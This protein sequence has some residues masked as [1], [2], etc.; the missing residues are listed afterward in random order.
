M[1]K[2]LIE[3]NL[4][5]A[6]ISEQ[7]ANE[8]SIRHGVPSSI[9]RWWARRPLT[10]SRA[11]AFSA[12][13]YDPG[14][15]NPSQ[16]A[17]LIDLIRHISTWDAIKEE[18]FKYLEKARTLIRNQYSKTP[19]IIDPFAGG[20]SI[21]LETLRLGCITYAYDYNPIAVLINKCTLEWPQKFNVNLNTPIKPH[22]IDTRDKQIKLGIEYLFVTNNVLVY[23]IQKWS[24]NIY[25]EI[26]NEIGHY[27]PIEQD[28]GL[29][30][31]F[32]WARTIKCQNPECGAEIPLIRQYWL[33]KKT[34]KKTAYYPIIDKKNK[35]V[36]F[37]ILE[38]QKSISMKDFNPDIG[39][40][41]NGDAKCL[42][43]G[44][45]IRS[46]KLRKLAS[47]HGLNERLIAV[48]ISHPKKRGK[49]Y[50]VANKNDFAVFLQARKHLESKIMSW[51]DI[52]SP[53]PDE[54][55]P[56]IG[57]LGFRV[58][59]YGYNK[60]I[61]LF[62]DRQKLTMF[63]VYEIIK[64]SHDYIKEDIYS[65]IEK[66]S[67]LK[68][69]NSEELAKAILGYL[70]IIFGNLLG[71][72]NSFCIY[73]PI[74]E[75]IRSIFGRQAI[76]MIWDYGE[77]NPFSQSS[78]SLSLI[79][80]Q[81]T[82]V[83]S[84]EIFNTDVGIIDI[85]NAMNLS[86]QNDTFDAIFTDPPYYDN[87]PYADLSDFYYVWFKRSIGHLFPELFGTPLVKK[88]AEVIM[89]PSRHETPEMAK[90]FFEKSIEKSFCEI[91]R[92]LKHGGITVIVYA[93]KSSDGWESMLNGLLSANFVVTASW[94]VHTETKS[95]LRA[96]SSATLASS[97][98]MVC[99]KIERQ[100]LGFWNEI[101]PLIQ[102][103]VE[104]KLTQFWNEGISGGDFFISAIGPGMEEY[105]KYERV[106]TYAGDPVG[107]D[108][109][110][111]FIRQVSTNFLVNRLLLDAQREAIDPEAQFYLTYR[112]TYLSNKVLFDDARK[113]ASAQGVDIEQYWGKGGFIKK[114]GSDIEVLGP[115]K[116]NEVE[117]IENMVDAMHHACQLW[118]KGRKTEI[119]RMLASH[120]Y[121]ESGA[122]WQFCQAIA[123]CL[124]EGSKEK[125]LLEGLLVGKDVYIRDSA[126][127]VAEL[128]KPKIEQRRLFE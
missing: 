35:T 20:G 79:T 105:S 111:A 49:Y 91:F 6:Y 58:Q 54:N 114:S 26:K 47:E 44:Q 5:L 24:K 85:A 71:L 40:V 92:I 62:N 112:W 36:E 97:I 86:F 46:S 94:P 25:N 38:G 29:P 75:A 9:H 116:R 118:E 42:I 52:D 99:R 72:N 82:K 3:W 37:T 108:K 117:E 73:E 69:I 81:I 123:E 125:Q 124:L 17:Y 50:R 33:S 120:G 93:H 31:G 104:K 30:F 122:F 23:F 41:N 67:N 83:L 100:P 121:A 78:G 119:S 84:N 95:R 14:E 1:K 88:N 63:Y 66:N 27:Y 109:L 34:N 96:R 22:E 76:P 65:L 102:A 59:R 70:T 107:V 98:Y 48:L 89:D 4:P 32:L 106:E 7:S 53:L 127:V 18:N 64:K 60:W 10:A 55:L 61:D 39:T 12:L 43:C 103:R 45:I 15:N 57:T 80:N 113:I 56:I 128:K 8:K 126:E 2:R 115:H 11:I 13:I 77:A 101:Q 19:I 51:D 90:Q 110:L 74:A 87:V 21:P 28:G 68:C 16:R